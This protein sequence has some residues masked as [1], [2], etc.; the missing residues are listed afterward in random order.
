WGRLRNPENHQ[1]YENG[2]SPYLTSFRG[3]T[4][5]EH[6]PTFGLINMN[7]RLYDPVLGRF[8]SPD[9]FV[10]DPFFSQNHNRY[11]YCWNNPLRFTD[12]NGEYI[13]IIVGAVVGGIVNWAS[14][15]CQFNAKGLAHFGVGAAAGALTAAFGPAGAAAGGFLL[16][17]VNTALAGGDLAAVFKNATIGAATGL[18]SSYTGQFAS[19]YLNNV[20]I[21][22]F[23][24]KSPVLQ[25]MIGGAV[26]GSLSGFTGGFVGELINSGSFENA[27]N[28]GWAG[29]KS[30]G[31]L[32]AAIG[33]ATGAKWAKDNNKNWWTGKDTGRN[34]ANDINATGNYTVYEGTDESGVR[35]VGITER[36]PEIRFAEHRNSG[37]ERA[38]LYYQSKHTGL[39]K[40]QARILEQ[41]LIN[42]YGLQK[43]GGQLYNKINSIAKKYWNQYG[44]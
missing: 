36:D 11:S 18:V 32:G 44:I 26:G 30:G 21:N 23:S 8:L 34:T 13:H 41:K 31:A 19:K 10:Q 9:P 5:H 2:Q 1:V 3:Y 22:G 27:V 7:A 12:P 29:A 20:V 35:Y 17:G 24:V 39:T 43:N 16:N 40:I 15:G 28:A 37:T 38:G 42:K 33:G 4:G 14:N 6:L 25:G